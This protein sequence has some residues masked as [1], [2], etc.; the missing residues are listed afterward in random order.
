MKL[1]YIL[2]F[3]FSLFYAIIYYI[4]EKRDGFCRFLGDFPLIFYG[5]S[6]LWATLHH[7][8]HN[9]TLSNYSLRF[10]TCQ[11]FLKNIRNFFIIIERKIPVLGRF[12]RQFF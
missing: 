6:S 8:K 1:F 12:F 11:A 9:D 3:T 7:Y 4:E 5:F 10:E 2:R